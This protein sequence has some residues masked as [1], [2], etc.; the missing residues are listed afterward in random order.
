MRITAGCTRCGSRAREVSRLPSAPRTVTGS[1]TPIRSSQSEH[2]TIA[3]DSIRASINWQGSPEIRRS[4]ARREYFV[5]S[6]PAEDDRQLS[7]GDGLPR[8]I[9]RVHDSVPALPGTA[10]APVD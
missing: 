1:Y 3:V 6:A 10:C 4:P 9:R 2:M 5:A 7:T 8:L